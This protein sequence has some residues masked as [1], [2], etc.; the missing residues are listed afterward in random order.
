MRPL[1]STLKL[2]MWDYGSLD[3]HQ[4]KEYI[5]EKMRMINAAM[6]DQEVL[7]KHCY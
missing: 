6:E 2:L 1:H 3:E 5:N 4:E 7:I